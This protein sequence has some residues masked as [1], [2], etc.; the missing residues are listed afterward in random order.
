MICPQAVQEAKVKLFVDDTN[1]L[2][3]EKNKTSL[4]DKS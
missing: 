2:L 4:K 1:I 3:I